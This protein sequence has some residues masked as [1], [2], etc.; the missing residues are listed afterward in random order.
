M[1]TNNRHFSE[2][3]RLKRVPARG[4]YDRDV[5]DGILDTMPVAHVG[6]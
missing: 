2:R 6:Y 4:S 1:S 3:V 5:I